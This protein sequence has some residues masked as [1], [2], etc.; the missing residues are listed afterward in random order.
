MSFNFWQ[1]WLVGVGLYHVLFG[2]LLAFFGQS[3]F[4][5]VMINQYYDPLFWPDNTISEGTIT[6][7]N[8]STSVLGAVVAS[9]GSFISF[10]A[11]YPFKSRENWAWNCIATSVLL[12]FFI[13]TGYSL[14]YG[15]NINAVFN[16]IT[17][18]LFLIPLLLTRKY[19]AT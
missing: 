8:W 15:V 6:Y 11:Y 9:W 12:W 3:R 13:D 4:M 17:L 16:L 5:D 14:Y 7:K 10:I 19:F 1:K 2:L 18:A